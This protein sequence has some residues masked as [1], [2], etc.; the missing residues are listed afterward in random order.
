MER[1]GWVSRRLSGPWGEARAGLADEGSQPVA[2]TRSTAQPL[3]RRTA[4]VKVSRQNVASVARLNDAI[5]LSIA[6]PDAPPSQVGESDAR[7]MRLGDQSEMVLRPR[8]RTGWL[9]MLPKHRKGREPQPLLQSTERLSPWVHEG[10]GGAGSQ[11][12]LA[13]TAIYWLHAF[14]SSATFNGRQIFV[15]AS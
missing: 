10:R 13:K 5:T 4:A 11:Q 3:G 6:I 2:P 9:T 8:W 1:G 15:S 7:N 12:S 14:G